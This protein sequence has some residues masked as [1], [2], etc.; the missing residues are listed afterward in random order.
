MSINVCPGCG[1]H[2]SSDAELD[3]SLPCEEGYNQLIAYTFS[4][5]DAD[6]IHQLVVDTYSSQHAIRESSHNMKVAFGLI[7]LYLHFEQGYS[8]REVQ[9]AHRLLAEQTKTWPRFIQKEAIMAITVSDVLQAL[10]GDDRNR[11]IEVWGRIVWDAWIDEHGTLA[12]LC[13]QYR[14]R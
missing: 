8:G 10:S 11:M 5:H 7:G 3:G 9:R 4:L 14:T 6:F 1:L 12:I 2:S 13:R